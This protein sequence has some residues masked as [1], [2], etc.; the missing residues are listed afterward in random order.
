MDIK[1]N[2]L[3]FPGGK[4]KA[5]TLSYDDGSCHDIRFLET[6]NKY[7]LKCT[8]NLVGKKIEK[9]EPLSREFIEENILAR[10]H[11]IAAHG[12]DHRAQNKIRTVEGIREILDCRLVLERTFGR[13]VRGF[14]FPDDA[15]NRLES[16]D[17]YERIRKYLPEL[18]VSYARS[19]DGDNDGFKLPSDWYNWMPS[20]HHTNPEVISASPDSFICGDTPRSLKRATAGS[21]LTKFA[22][23]SRARMTYGLPRISK[24]TITL[25]LTEA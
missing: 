10:G 22:R 3:R 21:C 25:R 5:V 11:E 8:F 1:Y 16:P 9:G 19:A 20:V 14:A 17:E 4:S 6:I 7:G 24:F 23:S 12:Y 2:F 15:V 13:I 18:D